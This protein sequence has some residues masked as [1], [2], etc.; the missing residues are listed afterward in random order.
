M[1]RKREWE[2]P[3]L[4]WIHRVRDESYRRTK[5]LPLETWLPPVDPE[6]AARACRRLGL[7]VRAV[8]LK[9]QKV[10]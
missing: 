3:S 8:R 6:K 2:F 7:R 10:G 9:R 5:G 1:P 4:E